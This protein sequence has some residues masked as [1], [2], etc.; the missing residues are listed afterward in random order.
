MEGS[1]QDDGPR[2]GEKYR[3]EQDQGRTFQW[4]ALS[5]AHRYPRPARVSI[6]GG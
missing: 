4:L 1:R 6:L 2:T 5:A 3:A